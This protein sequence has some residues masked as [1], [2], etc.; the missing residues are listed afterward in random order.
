MINLVRANEID[1]LFIVNTREDDRQIG[2]ILD[3]GFPIIP[4]PG[5]NHPLAYVVRIDN[6]GRGQ[7]RG[8]PSPGAGPHRHADMNYGQSYL[9]NVAAPA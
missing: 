8:S 5:A 6:R 4:R 1:G 2:A 3:S 7:E 9:L